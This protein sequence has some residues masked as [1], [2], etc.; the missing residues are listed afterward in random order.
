MTGIVALFFAT[1]ER[2]LL[3]G[4]MHHYVFRQAEPLNKKKIMVWSIAPNLPAWA[5]LDQTAQI[6]HQG[7]LKSQSVQIRQQ[8]SPG[9]ICPNKATEFSW[10][11]LPKLAN[12]GEFPGQSVNNRHQGFS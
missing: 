12:R 1:R 9:P 6:G 11:N 7:A 2:L 10:A 8:G 5:L 3:R 4:A